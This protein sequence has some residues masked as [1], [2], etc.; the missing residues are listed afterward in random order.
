MK[1]RS[2]RVAIPTLCVWQCIDRSNKPT[3]GRGQGGMGSSPGEKFS[4]QF[5]C[6]KLCFVRFFVGF[7]KTTQF[8]ITSFHFIPFYFSK[9]ILSWNTE[10]HKMGNL[11]SEI[12]KFVSLSFRISC[13]EQSSTGNPSQ[14]LYV[15]WWC[16]ESFISPRQKLWFVWF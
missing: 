14:K 2:S 4:S 6:K 15:L 13:A 16:W 9:V 5:S 7:V 12:S 11:F 1:T 3:G 8:H 10:F